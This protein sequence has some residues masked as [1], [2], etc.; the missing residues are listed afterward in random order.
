[1]PLRKGASL[2][3]ILLQVQPHPTLKQGTVSALQARGA[4]GMLLAL[5]RGMSSRRLQHYR[6]LCAMEPPFATPRAS[7]E[8][9]ACASVAWFSHR[10]GAV[11]STWNH[12]EL[13]RRYGV[14]I[15][16]ASYSL[17]LYIH[18]LVF[19]V[20][21]PPL[22]W[23]PR[24]W[25]PAQRPCLSSILPSCPHLVKFLANTMHFNTTCK[26]Y[27]PSTSIHTNPHAP[28]VHREGGGQTMT[29][30]RGGRGGATLEHIYVIRIR[31]Q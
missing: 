15:F 13:Q 8:K 24:P 19:R 4:S 31:A 17:Q 30:P 28:Q 12:K 21:L 5:K 23:T 22:V 1:M 2:L 18:A 29:M 26:N 7:Q 20:N 3:R 27:A 6:R 25:A 16:Q 9:G 14:E 10:L 11:T